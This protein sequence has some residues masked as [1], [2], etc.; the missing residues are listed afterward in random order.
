MTFITTNI[1]NCQEKIFNYIQGI[2]AAGKDRPE[3]Y[4]QFHNTKA[5]LLPEDSHTIGFPEIIPDFS[6]LRPSADKTS[7]KWSDRDGFCEIKA[8]KGQ[9]PK[10]VNEQTVREIVSQ[11]A[12]YARLHMSSRPFM[13]FS[14][15]LL[16]FGSDFCLAIFD[17]SGVT[18]SPIKNM[19]TNTEDFIRAVISLTCLLSDVELGQD[20]TALKLPPDV[21]R[22]INS[23]E[24]PSYLISP[25][26]NYDKRKWCTIGRP[27]W[28]SLSLLGRGTVVWRVLEYVDGATPDPHSEKII[29][30][31]W[32]DIGRTGEARIYEA[33]QGKRPWGL[34]D[35]LM[36]GDVMSANGKPITVRLLRGADDSC[37]DSEKTPVLHRVLLNS[38]GRPLWEY[39]SE[40]ELLKALR[41]ACLG[42]LC[43][44]SNKFVFELTNFRST[45]VPLETKHSSSRH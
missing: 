25:I 21:S 16:I 33:I 35:F 32:R 15:G 17:R 4:R 27:M 1:L 5:G 36:G 38:V 2:G 19:W 40:L 44:T 31:A 45:R 24:Y 10:P 6:L 3:G 28:S 41:A 8:T 37:V 22:K 7:R 13:L 11:A 43:A 30:T 34:A 39:N 26:A 23:D 29:K 14:V 18:F 12:D 42:R 9:G 20:P